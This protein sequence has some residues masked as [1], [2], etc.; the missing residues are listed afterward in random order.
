MK[1]FIKGLVNLSTKITNRLNEAYNETYGGED[2]MHQ[3]CE[4]AKLIQERNKEI[5][6]KQMT[7]FVI[8]KTLKEEHYLMP[9]KQAEGIAERMFE[10]AKQDEK[11]DI[12]NEMK[13][14]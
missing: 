9:H 14:V 2:Y 7:G 8:A 5:L 13:E 1:D 6:L 11:I 4:R 10:D 12:M 3:I